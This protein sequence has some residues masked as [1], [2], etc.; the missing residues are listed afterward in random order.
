M[1]GVTLLRRACDVGLRV[2]ADGGGRL[3]IRGPR[4]AEP[5]ARLLLGHK[6][7]VTAALAADWR[8]HH[9]EALAQWAAFRPAEAA[10]IAWGEL[11]ERWHRLH[12]ARAPEWQCVGC[13]EPIGGRAALRLADGNR[14]HVAD[15]LDC[16]FAFGERWRREAIAGLRALGLDPPAEVLMDTE[17]S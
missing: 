11:E 5:V 4:R 9:R 17:R 8:A 15:S 16:L 12:G 7:A 2:A 10:R 14:V 1:D 6:A 13:G 3:V